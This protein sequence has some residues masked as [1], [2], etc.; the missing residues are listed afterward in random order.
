MNLCI[1][2]IWLS[3]CFQLFSKFLYVFILTFIRSSSCYEEKI[4]IGKYTTDSMAFSAVSR[5]SST[6]FA[7]GI[8]LQL[9]LRL[10]LVVADGSS[11]SSLTP[12]PMTCPLCTCNA[13]CVTSQP[14]TTPPG[15]KVV[16][17]ALLTPNRLNFN[18]RLSYNFVASASTMAIAAAKKRG[19]LKNLD[20]K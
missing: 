5:E 4:A 1:V 2:G 17:I 13:D 15:R 19:Y 6:I 7:L 11:N 18:N 3:Y 8:P 20:I 12:S 16:N 9:A 14:M 10:V